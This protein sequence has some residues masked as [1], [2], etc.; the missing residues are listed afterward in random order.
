MFW[1][2]Q[3][4]VVYDE[5]TVRDYLSLTNGGESAFI[6]T[7]EY[8][9]GTMISQFPTDLF[10]KFQTDPKS[11]PSV[12]LGMSVSK[13]DVSKVK[14][15]FLIPT[16]HAKQSLPWLMPYRLIIRL[17]KGEKFISYRLCDLKMLMTPQGTTGVPVRICRHVLGLSQHVNGAQT[18]TFVVLSPSGIVTITSSEDVSYEGE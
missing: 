8:S 16:A 9:D 4:A 18:K 15:F 2:G 12:S 7:A 3:S 14:E 17:D 10:T 5:P 11:V 6:W 13:L 1:K